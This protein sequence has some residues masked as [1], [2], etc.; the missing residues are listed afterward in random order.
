MQRKYTDEKDKKKQTRLLRISKKAR[1]TKEC[2]SAQ[3]QGIPPSQTLSLKII[4]KHECKRPKLSVR[5]RAKSRDTAQ[6]PR[7][8]NESHTI[9]KEIE[10]APPEKYTGLADRNGSKNGIL[11]SVSENS[12]DSNSSLRSSPADI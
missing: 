6:P 1:L 7:S 2:K 8:T 12:S 3:V 10:P 11:A 9:R 4:Q 5:R